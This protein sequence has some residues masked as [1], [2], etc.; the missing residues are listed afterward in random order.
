MTKDIGVTSST[1]YSVETTW[2]EVREGESPRFRTYRSYGFTDCRDP[3]TTSEKLLINTQPEL[4]ADKLAGN[5]SHPQFA[6]PEPALKL[7][8]FLREF[9]RQSCGWEP[10][11]GW[12]DKQRGPID[13]RVVEVHTLIARRIVT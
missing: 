1:V 7:A 9:G 13:A 5:D 8:A 2:P 10:S 6:T 12:R 4:F 11:A 3:G